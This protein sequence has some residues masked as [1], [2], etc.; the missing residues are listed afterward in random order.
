MQSAIRA[1][2]MTI[3]KSIRF[4]ESART[5]CRN[6]ATEIWLHAPARA[7]DRL[8]IFSSVFHASES[9]ALL[10]ATV[11]RGFE[12]GVGCLGLLRDLHH[13]RGDCESV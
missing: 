8:T 4:G 13:A 6:R 10:A 2:T 7:R 3:I 11:R 5:S 12:A 1:P 9:R